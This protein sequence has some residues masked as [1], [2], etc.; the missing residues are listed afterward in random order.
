MGGVVSRCFRCCRTK[1]DEDED[2]DEYEDDGSM[3]WVLRMEQK[4][5]RPKTKRDWKI[6]ESVLTGGG[7]P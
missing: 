2:F 5:A 3:E 7:I 1:E 6:R 4:I